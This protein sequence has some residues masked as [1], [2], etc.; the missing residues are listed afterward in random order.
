MYMYIKLKN[1]HNEHGMESLWNMCDCACENQSYQF[2]Q[3]S[4]V[5]LIIFSHLIS[6]TNKT[7]NS[8]R[9]VLVIHVPRYQ[10]LLES[11]NSRLR[12]KQLNISVW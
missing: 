12:N 2:F 11:G 9:Y 5:Q 10:I 7:F 1:H 3:K 6:K 8:L 4:F